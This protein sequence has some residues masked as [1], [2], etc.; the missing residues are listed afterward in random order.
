M[1]Q[2][3]AGHG[4]TVT[5]MIFR[6][7]GGDLTAVQ[8][9][10]KEYFA[11]LVRLGHARLAVRRRPG[12]VD[13][14]DVALSAFAEFVNLA[15]RGKYPELGSRDD[16]WRLLVVITARKAWAKQR[17]DDRHG[18]KVTFDEQALQRAMKIDSDEEYQ[19]LAAVIGNEPD[20]A[21]GVAVAVEFDRLLDALEK[22]E[23]GEDLVRIA[24]SRM[25]GQTAPEIAG[26][27]H[28][29]RETVFRRIRRIK[30]IWIEAGLVPRS[31]D[32]WSS[33]EETD[34]DHRPDG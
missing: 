17:W 25:E 9:L 2:T 3:S 12:G 14:E 22:E 32:P 8:P 10:W 15:A 26:R 20:P 23:E 18:G 5:E 31:D 1:T 24:L 4:G 27:L 6:L 7:N 34:P 28:C 29:C 33:L 11:R 13:G 30:K 16:L 21:F 19:G